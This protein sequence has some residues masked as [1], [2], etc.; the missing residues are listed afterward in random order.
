MPTKRKNNIF[1]SAILF[2]AA[3]IWGF[4]FIPQSKATTTISFIAFNCLRFVQA[5]MAV[6][7]VVLA[8]GLIA[9]KLKIEV[10][11][12]N[13]DTLIGGSLAG[14]ALFLATNL[15]QYGLSLPSVTV[16]KASFITAMYIVF[17]PLLGLL[18]G[19]RPNIICGYAIIIAMV[20]F[21]LLC[22]EDD[23]S[24]GV[25]DV[26]ILLC[27]ILL[28]IQ[29]C[30]IDIYCDNVDPLKLSLIQFSVCAVLGVIA[31][32]IDGFPT[33]EE[34]KNSAFSLVYLGVMSAG[35]GFTL[36]TIGQRHTDPTIGTLVMSLES[37]IG[38]LCGA[39]FLKEGHSVKQ[40]I[41][42][43]LVFIAVFLAQI[44]F[45]KT[46][47]TF[48]KSNFAATERNKTLW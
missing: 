38:F 2:L 12:W 27:A 13:K 22:I 18:M 40:V 47:L 3:L 46:M 26:M 9:K 48:D 24:V 10:V 43:A 31:M 30:F 1:G 4:A 17:V 14:L 19:K 32:A 21:F 34:I 16:G 36:Q 37:I 15:Q 23:L 35:V 42:C 41:G 29:I 7:V 39:I 28:S 33:M 20:G 6:G 5:V 25:G 8:Y 45:P 44:E 11:K